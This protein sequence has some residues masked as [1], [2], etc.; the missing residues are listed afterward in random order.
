MK[1]AVIGG[2]AA[3]MM[4]A[5]VAAESGAQV[6]L[7]EKNEKLGKKIYITGKGRCNFTNACPPEDYLNSVVRNPRFMYSSFAAFNNED[8]VVFFEKNGLNTK[9]ERGAR[10]FPTSDKASDVTKALERAM[11]GSGVEIILNAKVTSVF[12]TE[13]GFFEIKYRRGEEE[14]AR[15]FDKVIV[16]TGGLSYPSTGSDGDGYRFAGEAGHSVKPRYPSLVSVRTALPDGSS[17]AA[18]AGLSP[19]NISLSLFDGKKKIFEEFGEMLFTHDG[20]SGPIVLTLSARLPEKYLENDCKLLKKTELFLDWKPALLP[21]QLETRLLREFDA[22]K[23][24]S[25]K[26]VMRSLL[27]ESA[28]SEV[29]KQAGI[30][31]ETPIHD[32]TREQRQELVCSLKKFRLIPVGLGGYNEAVITRGGVNVREINPAT[33]ESK[34]VP[35]LFFAGEVLDID[36]LTGGFNLQLAWSTGH[37]AGR[38]AANE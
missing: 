11:L 25:L 1:V 4:A 9:T 31:E 30:P 32:V 26:N 36:A 14:A 18:M 21:E 22:S 24:K 28:I 3:G 19:K 38:S 33:M 2:G 34:L 12:K 17:V 20:I 5:A 7:F 13:K 35:G 29:L 23:N 27:P 8:A 6:A 37:A 15:S 10:V 16:A